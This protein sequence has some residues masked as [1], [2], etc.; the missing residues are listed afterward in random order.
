MRKEAFVIAAS[1]RF[2]NGDPGHPPFFRVV[3]NERPDV[4]STWATRGPVGELGADIG[5]YLVTSTTDSGT[6]MNENLVH[7]QAGPRKR[8]EPRI[9][10]SRGGAAPS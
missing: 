10:Y 5:A 7:R 8:V 1:A 4:D 3:S 2:T 6:Q 9:D